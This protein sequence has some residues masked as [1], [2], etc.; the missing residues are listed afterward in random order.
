MTVNK[1]PDH[2]IE[3]LGL[4]LSMS[5]ITDGKFPV[6]DHSIEK[7][8][9]KLHKH[10]SRSGIYSVPDHS[11]EKLGLKQRFSVTSYRN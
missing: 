3:K 9:L 5:I 11:I 10:N 7:L 2:S 6:P 1:V 4:K 8:G